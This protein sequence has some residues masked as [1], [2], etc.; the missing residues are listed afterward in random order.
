MDTD[1]NLLFGVLALQAEL[2]DAPRFAEACAAWAARKNIALADLLVE[3]G[4]L[5]ADDRALLNQLLER[6]LRK[7]GGD[8]QS[9]LAAAADDQARRLLAALDDSAV[10]GSLAGLSRSTQPLG[11]ADAE[12][13]PPT[14]GAVGRYALRRLHATGGI[15]RVWLAWDAAIG[16]EVA[17]KEPRPEHG[18]S[19]AVWARFWKEA[20]VTGQ[21]EHPGIVPIYELARPGDGR[22]PFYVMRFVKGRT[23]SEAVA[24]Y[25]RRP[26]GD[27]DRRLDFRALL[28]AFVG[29]CNAVGY[30]HQR[31]VLH[32]DLK[33]GNVVLGDFGEVIVLDWGLA[34]LVGRPG[35]DPDAPGIVLDAADGSADTV[36]GQ[37]LGTP[38]FMAPEQAAGRLDLLD[39]RTD[40]YGLGAVLYQILTGR[41]P[42][43]GKDAADVLR[44]VAEEVPARPRLLDATVPPALEAVCLRALA[45]RPEERYP[46]A[47]ELAE[48]VQRFLADEVVSAYREPLPARLGRWARRHRPLVAGA[49]ALLVTAVAALTVST[50]LIARQ[51][52]ETDRARR[53]AETNYARALAAV[54]QMLTAVGQERLAHV[55]GMERV[56]RLL[57]DEALAFYQGFL[58]ERSADPA[59]RLET[60]RAAQRVAKI[61]FLMGQYDEAEKA[62]RE[63]AGLFGRLVAEDGRPA[64]YRHELARARADLGLLLA[65]RGRDGEAATA[66]DEAGR[67]WERLLAGSPGNPDYERG[68]AA[69]E[70]NRGNLLVAAG[71]VD[72]AGTAFRRALDLLKRLAADFPDRPDYRQ[73]LVGGH[74]SLGNWLKYTGKLPEA[75]T[76]FRESLRVAREL[77]AAYPDNPDYRE[78]CG[79]AW[80][81]LGDWLEAIGQS[82][83]AEKAYREA[84]KVQEQLA[85]DF[86]SF[87]D[88]RA[89][90][91]AA[92]HNLGN[93]LSRAGRYPDAEK[94]LARAVEVQEKLAAGLAMVRE[95]RQH[96]GMMYNSHGNV[97]RGL[98]RPAD[99]ERSY[100]RAEE[101]AARLLADF[102]P[103]PDY[104]SQR[105]AALHNRA[106]LLLEQHK[107]G[108]ARPCIEEAIAVQTK[109]LQASPTVASYRQ[110]LSDHYWVLASLEQHEGKLEACA[111]A[112]AKM[113]DVY[114]DRWQERYWAAYLLAQCVPAAAKDEKRPE[115]ARAYGDQAM[116]RLR[117]AVERGYTNQLPLRKER[118]FGPLA[119]RDDFRKLAAE[120]EAKP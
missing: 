69:C 46:G 78:Y 111:A 24:A 2:L 56:R 22:P 90:V 116:R 82:D 32:R 77:T 113:I 23:L 58:R 13:P 117:E 108:E 94:A 17:L 37:V 103:V 75:G 60:G 16:R 85:D 18:T 67:L 102:G 31:G 101:V 40:V 93:L 10:Q 112:T 79:K 99:A 5:T 87:P 53:R 14:T 20:Q 95:Y 86:P 70:S 6:R 21:L 100:R 30:A 80:H 71:R 15:G 39:R 4:W 84:L 44:R 107:Y 74:G 89:D 42:F 110:H 3:R 52:D 91:A 25:H 50:V 61:R 47:K 36:Q 51:R 59:L 27:P 64:E 19:P 83:E 8:V 62:Y 45:K 92:Y 9:S 115:L 76:E 55:P 96:L 34:R 38:A 29:V 65:S 41:P 1:R 105:G 81:N 72:E 11:P 114:P 104:E 63:A 33:G 7:H 57:L 109:A 43:A 88:Y 73:Q 98:K 26:A 97:L 28:T 54:D 66:Y 12:A 119:E 106:D 120:V 48:D 118:A 35:G 68:L 49:A